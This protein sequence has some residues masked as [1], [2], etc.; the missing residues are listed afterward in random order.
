MVGRDCAESFSVEEDMGAALGA[1]KL[2][3]LKP[4]VYNTAACREVPM[5]FQ[6]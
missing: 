6:E 5:V 3:V 2:G 4:F 1:F